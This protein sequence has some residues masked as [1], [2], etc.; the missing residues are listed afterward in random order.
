MFSPYFL[1]KAVNEK[2]TSERPKWCS[3]GNISE[4]NKLKK[5]KDDLVIGLQL[6]NLT[7]LGHSAL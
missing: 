7:D 1:V 6:W 3:S 2:Q 5:K 4:L